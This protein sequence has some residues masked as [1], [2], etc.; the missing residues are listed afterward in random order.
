[1]ALI[2]Q[3]GR[4]PGRRNGNLPGESHGQRSLAGCSLWGHKE[5]DMTEV[6]YYIHVHI[7]LK[8]KKKQK[9]IKTTVGKITVDKQ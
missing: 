3:S 4:F 7:K 2:P 6:T 5:S 8:K 9:E 1:M